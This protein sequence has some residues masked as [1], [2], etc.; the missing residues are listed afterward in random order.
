MVMSFN[1]I[2]MGMGGSGNVYQ[3]V[4]ASYACGY[5][6]NAES[7]KPFAYPVETTPEAIKPQRKTDWFNK[8]VR[9]I[10]D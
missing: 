2:G 9:S 3:A 4:R 5:T 10:C 6:D 8:L 7:P 1:P